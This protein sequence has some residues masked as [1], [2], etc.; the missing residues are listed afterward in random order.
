[1]RSFFN[2]INSNGRILNKDDETPEPQV[3]FLAPPGRSYL[4]VSFSNI[5]LYA[6]NEEIIPGQ[7]IQLKTM[8]D[9]Q[10]RQAE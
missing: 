6:Y 2:S 3:L 1:M 9:D 10:I 5:Q 8:T 7:P 4:F